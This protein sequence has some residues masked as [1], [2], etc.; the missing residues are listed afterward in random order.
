LVKEIKEAEN[1]KAKARE[2]PPAFY[3]KQALS[4]T[5]A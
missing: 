4:V 1:I 5:V 3:F 2:I